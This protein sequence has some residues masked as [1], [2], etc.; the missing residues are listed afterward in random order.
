MFLAIDTSAGCDVALVSAEGA[1]LAEF[2]RDDTRHHAEAIGVGIEHCLETAGVAASEVTE[3]VAGIGPGPF[4]GLRVGVAAAR[5]FAL[6]RGIPCTSVPSHDAIAITARAEHP[7]AT[8]V[9]TTDAR[10]RQ[11]A[12]S[13]YAP[14]SAAALGEPTLA[15]PDEIALR[16]GEIRVDA[17]QVRAAALLEA[18]RAR[19]EAGEPDAGDALLYLREPDAVPSQGPK[20]V[21]A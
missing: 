21:T 13:R 19:R 12:V 1:P 5:S 17:D 18:L 11:R 10:R 20:R 14:G 2:R 6:A 15:A 8:L 4:T 3:V 7:D 16:A 9:V